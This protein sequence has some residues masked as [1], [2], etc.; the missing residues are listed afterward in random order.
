LTYAWTPAD[1]LDD[2]A[3][4]RPN[5]TGRDD[6]IVEASLVVSDQTG[7]A[8]AATATVTVT[9]AVPSVSA[10]TVS[11]DPAPLGAQVDAHAGFTDPGVLDTHSASWDWGDG[12]TTTGTVNES[13]GSGTASGIH[14]YSS[15]DIYTIS[16]TVSDDDGGTATVTR[17]VVV[18]AIDIKPGSSVNTIPIRSKLVPVAILSSASFDATTQVDRSSLRFGRTGTEESLHPNKRGVPVCETGDVNGDGRTDLTCQ[19]VVSKTGFRVADT[20]GILSGGTITGLTFQARDSV[21]ITS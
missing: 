21:L 10:I 15:P 20:V 13:G 19:F 9:N 3:A 18:G 4:A 2:A 16:L 8:A 12:S 6:E 11:P 17:K 14:T 1:L 7:Q 5:L